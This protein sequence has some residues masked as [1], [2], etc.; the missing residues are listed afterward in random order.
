MICWSAVL[1]TQG[2][3]SDAFKHHQQLHQQQIAVAVVVVATQQPHHHHTLRATNAFK[4]KH[5]VTK[6]QHEVFLQCKQFMHCP[7]VL[8]HLMA[9]LC[10]GKSSFFSDEII[11]QHTSPTTFGT[12]M[13]AHKQLVE[14]QIAQEMERQHRTALPFTLKCLFCGKAFIDFG[15]CFVLKCSCCRAAFCGWSLEDC[16]EKDLKNPPGY[17]LICWC[18]VR[19]HLEVSHLV[20]SKLCAG[21][22]QC[23][24]VLKESSPLAHFFE[25]L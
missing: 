8:M 16:G 13:Q 21:C 9:D 2:V 1:Q 4:E 12:Y 14:Q 6:S 22:S 5:V 23:P 20:S 17:L 3:T 11:S 15:G 24:S 25:L 10:A 7:G 19:P 18:C